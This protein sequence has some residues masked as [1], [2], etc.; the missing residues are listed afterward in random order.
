MRLHRLLPLLLSSLLSTFSAAFVVL[1]SNTQRL[2][3]T[4]SFSVAGG[5][6]PTISISTCE[7]LQKAAEFMIDAFWLNSPQGLVLD[8][9][10]IPDS[11]KS[12]LVE[13]Q[14]LDFEDK[15]GERL[16]QRTLNTALL[17]AVNEDDGEI[18]GLAAVEVTLLDKKIGDTISSSKSENLIKTT[19]ASLGPK[20]RRAYKN[21]PV[22]QICEELMSPD[23]EAVAVLSNLVVSPS[24][25]R[26]GIAKN[27][28]DAVER[29]A[30]D[31][32]RYESLWLRVEADNQAAR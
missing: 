23:L 7:N 14:L 17:Q 1:P 6:A 12:S 9:G 13:E 8:E 20:E 28:S 24:A 31:E 16:G 27:L 21:A 26:L 18:V 11:T 22:G 19:V 25:R 2:S 32:W 29:V 5:A 15:Y 3:T 10:D 30:A 4:T